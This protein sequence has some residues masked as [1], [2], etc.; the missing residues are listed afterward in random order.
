MFVGVDIG[1]SS[2]R[3]AL[4][5]PHGSSKILRR[6]EFRNSGNYKNDLVNLIAAIEK[7]SPQKIDGIHVGIAGILNSR[8]TALAHSSNLSGWERCP[9][10]ND[11]VKFFCCKVSLEND[12]VT[13]ARGEALFGANRGCDFLFVIW[14]SGIGGCF[15]N[16]R[17]G[18]LRLENFELGHIPFDRRGARCG[19]GRRG[20]S[21]VFCGGKGIYRK[22]K[23]EPQNLNEK[24]WVEVCADF[25]KGLRKVLVSRE[26]PLVV[27]GGGISCKQKKHVRQIAQLLSVKIKITNLGEDAGLIGGV[28]LLH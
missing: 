8:K 22:Y 23:K 3:V 25:A 9:L 12:T 13:A 1:G 5:A 16:F 10:K 21:E 11:L 28:G 6:I 27:F 7:I 17:N 20:C 26:I 2:S 19:C 15:V 4:F 24:E 18:G 14:G